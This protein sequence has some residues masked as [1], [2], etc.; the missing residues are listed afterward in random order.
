MSE[1]W[2]ILG[3]GAIGSLMAS[4]LH[5]S[6][7]P[8]VLLQKGDRPTSEPLLLRHGNHEYSLPIPREPSTQGDP[9]HRLMITTKANQVAVA[10]GQVKGRLADDAIVVLLHNGMGTLE[11][12]EH[13]HDPALIY[14]GITTEAAYRTQ[15]SELVYAG[16]GSTFIGRQ[17]IKNPPHWFA[18]LADSEIQA[19]WNADI[20]GAQWR[21]LLINCAINP[22]TA[23]EDCRNGE[24]LDG[25]TR[26]LQLGQ[27]VD[28]LISVATQLLQQPAAAGLHEAVRQVIV[29]TADN[30]S[31]MQRDIHH[32][33]DCEID[34]ITGYLCRLA[35]AAGIACPINEALL[36]SVRALATQGDE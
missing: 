31:S 21:K 11:Q 25:D 17:G 3:A 1:P 4:H 24:L 10:F 20:V 29:D 32:A 13:L 9:I 19:R 14:S 16:Q 5:R 28:E 23:I 22:L 6:G 2:Y 12:I 27:C 34:Y 30:Y 33:R 18:A 8:V 26:E 35:A 15:G 36:A 7:T